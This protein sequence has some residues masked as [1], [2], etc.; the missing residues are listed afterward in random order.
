MRKKRTACKTAD[1]LSALAAL[2]LTAD[3]H[4]FIKWCRETR[5]IASQTAGEWKAFIG[6]WCQIEKPT[7]L[8]L[9]LAFSVALLVVCC[10]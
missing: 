6:D 3:V 7:M 2:C 5:T 4:N 9:N 10:S 8:V 1:L